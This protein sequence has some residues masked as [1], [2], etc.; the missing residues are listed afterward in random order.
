MIRALAGAGAV[1]AVLLV[2]GGYIYKT[3]CP[4]S[5]GGTQTSWT[6]GIN[7]LLPYIRS[8]S[9]P[10]TSHTAT[11]L[12]L[13]AIGIA[14]IANPAS[15][16]KTDVLGARAL[17]A[18]TAAINSEYALERRQI[19]QLK[20][21]SGLSQARRSSLAHQEIGLV[22][23]HMQRIQTQL[24]N[25]PRSPDT[26]LAAARD[27][28]RQWFGYQI[29]FDTALNNQMTKAELTALEGRIGPQLSKNVTDLQAAAAVVGAKYP[30]VADWSFLSSTHSG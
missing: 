26:D 22:V 9:A 19:T 6:Y 1:A 16:T 7:D 11:R 20:K 8:T 14:R 25:L 12:A 23:T 13:S 4:L 10:C 3:S 17:G 2:N 15:A 30:G 21:K 18:V 27:L 29:Q 28:L 24:T 5:S